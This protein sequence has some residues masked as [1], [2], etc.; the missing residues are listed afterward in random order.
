MRREIFGQARI[1]GEITLSAPKPSML[2]H[3]VPTVCH[4]MLVIRIPILAMT[5]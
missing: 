4:P 2:Q 1:P 3:G 5:C